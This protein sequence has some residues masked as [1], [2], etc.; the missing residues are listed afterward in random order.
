MKKIQCFII[1]SKRS[2]RQPSQSSLA[3]I[4]M[5]A[6]ISVA[7]SLACV[8]YYLRESPRAAPIYISHV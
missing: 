5:S 1:L 2:A 7:L 4:Q 6:F 3:S 8:L